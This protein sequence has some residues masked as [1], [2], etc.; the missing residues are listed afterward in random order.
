MQIAMNVFIVEDSE[1][2]RNQLMRLLDA[3]P[4]IRVVGYAETCE[5][6][7]ELILKG[8]PD[9]VL[10][11]I[12]LRESSGLDVLSR[13]RAAGYRS[14]VLVLTNN[15]NKAIHHA[16]EAHGISGFY[17]KT[18]ETQSCMAALFSWLPA[19]VTRPPA[20]FIGAPA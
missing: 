12:A 15:P 3:E 17:D 16:C 10:L 2:V 1:L 14:R 19:N 5:A 11:D 9:A 20:P 18:L 8:Q 6:A 4:R 13:I 7:V